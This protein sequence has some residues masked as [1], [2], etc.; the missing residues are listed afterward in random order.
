MKSIKEAISK[1]SD[2]SHFLPIQ[3]LGNGTWQFEENSQHVYNYSWTGTLASFNRTLGCDIIVTPTLCNGL[4]LVDVSNSTNGVGECSD[5]VS[6]STAQSSSSGMSGEIAA[7]NV[8]TGKLVWKTTFPNLIMTQP[9][10]YEG[11]VIVGLGNNLMQDSTPQVR[12]TGANFIAA[13][14]FSN[15]KVVWTFNTTGENMPTP[16]I[17]DGQVIEVNGDGVIYALNALT[18]QQVWDIS[19]PS[20]SFDSMSS[21]ALCGDLIFFG[22]HSPFTFYCVNLTDRQ[23]VWSTPVPANGGLDDCSPIVWNGEVIS[24][25]TVRTSGGLYEPILFAL[26]TTNGQILWQLDENTGPE[27]PGIQVPPDAVWNDIVYSDPTE[28]GVL[29]A[30][31]ASSGQLLWQFT[32]GEDNANVNVY[33]G[34]LWLVN[35]N[36]TL[37]VLNPVT[38]LLLNEINVGAGL[39]PGGLIFVG[40]NIIICETNGKVISM[41]ASNIYPND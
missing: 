1:T 26:N 24:G 7:I 35:N 38:G 19:L 13:L 6:Q 11:L 32:T 2:L 3:N 17:Y 9:L 30:V 36:G 41:P 15:G 27:P 31:N 5:A 28:S 25:Y 14:N 20:G 34:Y 10:T 18:G 37:F 21:P 8:Q 29:Y 33:D 16:L 40:E 22:A 12:G 23:I 4:L 39:G